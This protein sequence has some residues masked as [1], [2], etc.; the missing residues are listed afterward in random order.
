MKQLEFWKKFKEY[1]LAKKT[2][3]KMRKAYP[4]HWYDIAVGSSQAHL[5][6]IINTRDNKMG[7]QFYIPNNKKLFYELQKRKEQIE[8]ELNQKLKWLELPNKK[9]SAIVI[10]KE[11]D[12]NKKEEWNSY[13]EWLKEEAEKFKKVFTKHLKEI[14]L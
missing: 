10:F 12:I 9:A 14:K 3:L 7:C 8:K 4:Q 5:S 11:A 2:R 1:A 6:L 13:F